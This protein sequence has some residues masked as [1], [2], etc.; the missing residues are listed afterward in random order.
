MMC[1]KA[2]AQIHCEIDTLA[3][4]NKEALYT[5]YKSLDYRETIDY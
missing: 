1:G 3:S 4:A 5:P 2:H